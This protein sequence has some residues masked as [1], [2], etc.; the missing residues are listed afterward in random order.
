MPKPARAA[1]AA[2]LADTLDGVVKEPQSTR[3]WQALLHCGSSFLHVPEHG[4][5]WRNVSSILLN[6]LKTV[7]TSQDD[8]SDLPMINRKGE[9]DLA[10]VAAISIKLEEG[11]ISASVRILYSDDIPANFSSSNHDRLHDKHLSEHTGAHPSGLWNHRPQSCCV[12]SQLDL[13]KD[14]MK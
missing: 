13:L 4:G 1:C 7:L 11:N 9:A 10:R 3:A 8:Y 6:W 2:A 5:K 14:Q 12:L